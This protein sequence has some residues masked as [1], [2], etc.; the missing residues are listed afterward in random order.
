[1]NSDNKQN[2]LYGFIILLLTALFY[3]ISPSADQSAHGILL[4]TGAKAYSQTDPNSIQLYQTMPARAVTLGTIRITKHF[5]SITNAADI[6]NQNSTVKLARQLASTVGANAV[7]I[8]MLGRTYETG[9]LDGFVLY[10][11]A[12]RTY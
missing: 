12:I 7:V 8:T 10:A 3:I 11:K 5:D 9:P 2:L 4:P 1:M 6:S